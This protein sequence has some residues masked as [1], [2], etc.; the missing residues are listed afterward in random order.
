MLFWGLLVVVMMRVQWAQN[1]I[2]ISKAPTLGMKDFSQGFRCMG[3]EFG[4]FAGFKRV[5]RV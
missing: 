3:S 5:F 4:V 1:P 2:L